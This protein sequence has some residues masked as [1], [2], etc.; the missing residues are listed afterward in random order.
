LS[1]FSISFTSDK[2]PATVYRVAYPGTIQHSREHKIR[3][4]KE[5]RYTRGGY[6]KPVITET[7]QKTFKGAICHDCDTN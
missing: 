6:W 1:N 3:E 7:L 2:F 4:L 5:V